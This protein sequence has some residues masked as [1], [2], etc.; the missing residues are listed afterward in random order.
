MQNTPV[1]QGGKSHDDTMKD[2]DHPGEV[3]LRATE[4][5][6]VVFS[7]RKD[8]VCVIWASATG[9]DFAQVPV[10]AR[11]KCMTSVGNA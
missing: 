7:E 10:A 9:E 1:V 6:E 5:R 3:I 11:T 2:L 4:L 8:E